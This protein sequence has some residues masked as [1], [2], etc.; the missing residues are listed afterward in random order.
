MKYPF[1]KGRE[2]EG[3]GREKERKSESVC[4]FV[5]ERAR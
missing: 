3:G 1:V 5:R 4:V 2:K